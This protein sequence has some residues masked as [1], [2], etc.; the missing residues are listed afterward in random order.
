MCCPLE[1]PLQ[2]RAQSHPANG[3][4]SRQ[5]V[6]SRALRPWLISTWLQGWPALHMSHPESCSG[7]WQEMGEQLQGPEPGTAAHT[8]LAAPHGH[9]GAGDCHS[10]SSAC[11][12][13]CQDV[14]GRCSGDGHQPGVAELGR[15]LGSRSAQVLRRKVLEVQKEAG[16]PG[17][18]PALLSR[19]HRTALTAQ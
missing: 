19:L 11:V 3:Q 10:A 15:D 6:P 1:K 13:L 9:R 16:T 14:L 7:L 18:D 5:T 8:V 2:A 17:A 12:P 4:A